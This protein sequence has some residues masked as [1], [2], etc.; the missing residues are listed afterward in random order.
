MRQELQKEKFV[1]LWAYDSSSLFTR[2]IGAA[3]ARLPKFEKIISFF[4]F[5][6]PNEEQIK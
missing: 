3:I 6:D 1:V 5:K 4:F 2:L